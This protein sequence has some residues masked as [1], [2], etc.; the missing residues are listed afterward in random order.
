MHLLGTCLRLVDQLAERITGDFC[1]GQPTRLLAQAIVILQPVIH[2]L[3]V[4]IQVIPGR[5]HLAAGDGF[6]HLPTGQCHG[7]VDSFGVA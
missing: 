7:E 4:Q 5:A 1:R 3:A 2:K 6:F